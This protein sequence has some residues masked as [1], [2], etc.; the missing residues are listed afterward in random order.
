[1][2]SDLVSDGL[3]E[4]SE[5]RLSFM[6]CVRSCGV[7]KR[8]NLRSTNFPTPILFSKK[9]IFDKTFEVELKLLA[10]FI[11]NLQNNKI[12]KK[13]NSILICFTFFYNILIS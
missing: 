13:D 5:I 6:F 2:S 7:V 4:N 1:M 9:F 3:S 12:K 11:F 8:C 10:P